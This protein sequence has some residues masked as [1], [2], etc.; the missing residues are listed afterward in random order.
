[1]FVQLAEAAGETYPIS[2]RT[3]VAM[4]I[5]PYEESV[6]AFSGKPLGEKKVT[7]IGYGDYQS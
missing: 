7:W 1:M 5:F 6:I 2:K 4:I 3:K